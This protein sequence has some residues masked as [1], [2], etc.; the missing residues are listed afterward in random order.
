MS[1]PFKLTSAFQPRGD[2]A[3]AIEAL[4]DSFLRGA[5]A[6]VLL[7][8][9]GSGKSTTIAS[10]LDWINHRYRKHILTLEDPLEFIHSNRGC[11]INQRQI[12]EH[13]GSFA[14][15]L[16][17]ALRAD[18]NVIPLASYRFARSISTFFGKEA[19]SC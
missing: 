15:A 8:I 19:P 10:M 6:Q 16:R 14:D 18:P 7:G 2:Q 9:T 3:P 4:T 5:D 12:G 1:S 17:G 13:S 11:L